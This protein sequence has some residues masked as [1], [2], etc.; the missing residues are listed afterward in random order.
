MMEKRLISHT[1]HQKY[2]SP[3][4]VHSMTNLKLLTKNSAESVRLG[5]I[6]RSKVIEKAH[7]D[8]LMIQGKVKAS[9]RRPRHMAKGHIKQFTWNQLD[10]TNCVLVH[11]N[12]IL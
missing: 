1:K 3:P 7:V 5:E 2:S 4:R 8:K 11:D 9:F 6:H 10:R 12:L